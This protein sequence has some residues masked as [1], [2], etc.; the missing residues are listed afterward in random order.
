[1][2]RSIQRGIA[3]ALRRGVQIFLVTVGVSL[4]PVVTAGTSFFT[5]E[6]PVASRSD[7]DRAIAVEEGLWRILARMTGVHDGLEAHPAGRL[8]D[9]ADRFLEGF[10]YIRAEQGQA[11]ELRFDGDVLRQ[12]LGEERIPIWDAHRAPVLV[13]VAMD[14]DG[15]RE[16]LGLGHGSELYR[17]FTGTARERAI[18]LLFPMLDLED[19]RQVGFVQLWGGF[20]W[21]VREASRRYGSGPVLAVA[22]RQSAQTGAWRGRWTLYLGDEQVEFQTG[23]GSLQRIVE[24]G[25]NEVSA[26]LAQRY[27]VVPGRYAGRVL[28]IGVVGVDGLRDFAEVMAYLEGINGVLEADVYRVSEG[29]IGVRLTLQRDPE[30][31]LEELNTAPSLMAEAL[32]TLEAGRG[33]AAEAARSYRWLR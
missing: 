12:R 20:D 2:A 3:A 32:P 11:V 10:R 31:V 14:V 33:T 27:A 7:A 19:R 25:F 5:V 6:V 23:P 30:R 17:V 28:E 18:P 8:L 15:R 1:M 4:T 24:A 16:L 13:W 26:V 22:V 21:T 29:R 9:D